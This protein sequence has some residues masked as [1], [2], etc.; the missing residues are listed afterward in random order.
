M[1]AREEPHQRGAL[2]WSLKPA[3]SSLPAGV[4]VELEACSRGG[5]QR[6]RVAS[7]GKEVRGLAGHR[8]RRDLGRGLG[9]D[10]RGLVGR[11]RRQDLGRGIGIW[12]GMQGREGERAEDSRVSLSGA[13]Y[14]PS[15][16]RTA[17]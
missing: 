8:Q 11:R 5:A 6:R 12:G 2:G 17:G 7:P 1:P 4:A 16:L 14:I 9:K 13:A 3:W 10:G 15:H